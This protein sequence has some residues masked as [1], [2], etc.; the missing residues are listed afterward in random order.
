VAKHFSH[1]SCPWHRKKLMTKTFHNFGNII[2]NMLIPYLLNGRESAIDR[3]LD[4]STYPGLMLVLSSLCK[5][6][7]I[8]GIGNAI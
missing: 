1:S 3:A 7:I 5:K 6:K 4:G 8:L 2:K